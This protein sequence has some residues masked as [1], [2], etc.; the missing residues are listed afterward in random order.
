MPSNNHDIT[1]EQGTTFDL[2]VIWKDFDGN[3]I[4][5]NGYE[6][7][8]QIRTSYPDYEVFADL[9]TQDSNG[10]IAINDTQGRIAVT[11]EAGETEL[12]SIRRGVYDLEVISP[13]GRVTRL[14]EG[15]VNITAEVTR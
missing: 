5:L 6:A 9:D 10:S 2:V 3:P 15:A 14:L 1:I 12:L 11:L 13:T 7:R 8:M 4:N